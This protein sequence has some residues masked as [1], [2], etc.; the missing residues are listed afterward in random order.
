[1]FVLNIKN[2][3][4]FINLKEVMPGYFQ[5][6]FENGDYFTDALQS[7]VILRA[8]ENTNILIG[9][10]CNVESKIR[11][12]NEE[13]FLKGQFRLRELV[14]DSA[15]LLVSRPD[16]PLISTL[17]TL[18][19]LDVEG[20][21]NFNANFI[22]DDNLLIVDK[23]NKNVRINH[24]LIPDPQYQLYVNSNIFTHFIRV[25][26]TVY[27]S[28]LEVSGNLK[29]LG[30]VNT[31]D[32]NILLTERFS[33]SNDG[34]GP[35][36][37]VNQTGS[38]DIAN[39]M[40]DSQSVLIMKDGGNVGINTIYPT[41]KLTVNGNVLVSSNL[42]IQQNLIVNNVLY[43]SNIE[44]VNTIEI[45]GLNVNIN[46]QLDVTN[47]TTFIHNDVSLGKTV[48]IV[49]TLYTSNIE[50][51]NTI[52]VIGSNVNVKNQLDVTDQVT[53]IHNDVS[54]AK[55]VS[56][57]ETL[58]TSNIESANTIEIA[59]ANVNIKNQLDVTDP[60]TFIH[61]DVS[62][63]KNVSIE[64]TLYTSNIESVNTI[65]VIGS[66]VN[67]KN[68][69]NV[70][71]PVTFI[72]NDV[73]L[74]KNVSIADTLYTSNINSLNT[75]N[76][77]GDVS[78][79]NNI[80]IG[81]TL[82]INDIDGE[83]H[84]IRVTTSGAVNIKDELVVNT[85][86][87]FIHND[88]SLAK[89]VSIV[90]TL[91]TS[92]IESANTIEITGAN[93]NVK[94]LLD[95][96][97]PVTFIHN[98]V[99]LAKNVSIVE[100][101]YTSNIES[102]NT[103]EITGANVN[104]KN[105]LDV[106]D[107]VTFIH[108][109]VSIAKNVSIV[110]TLYTSNI[111]SV[112]TI[113][114]TGAN[115]NVKNVLDVTDPVT[116]IHNDVSIAKNV[117][118]VETLYTSNIESVNTIEITGANVNVKN[119]LDVTDQVTFIH[120]D[121]SIARNISIENTIYT[122]N[123][124]ISGNFKVL[125]TVNTIDTNIILT[126]RFAVSN[127]GTGPAL[128]ITQLGVTDIAV[129]YDD[130][131]VALII[132]DGGN[133]GINTTTPSE[134][135]T[136][137]G[138]T[139]ISSNLM[140]K[141]DVHF[142]ND[143]YIDNVLSTKSFY[144]SNIIVEGDILQVPMGLETKRPLPINAPTGCIFYNSNTI[145]FEGLHD[146]GGGVKEWLPFGGVVD[147]DGDTYITAENTP[148]DNKLTF[149]AGNEVNPIAVFTS[150]SLSV[151]INA[152]FEERLD[153]EKQVT[154]HN[155]LEV[156]NNAVFDQTVL[157]LGTLS[158]GNLI[159]DTLTNVNEATDLIC[160]GILSVNQEAYLTNDTYIHQD[161]H[162]TQ[163]IYTSN[164]TSSNVH[165]NGSILKIPVG[166]D[167][168]R[169]LTTA[170]PTGSIYYNEDTM[171]FE[172][173][174]DLTGTKEW[175]AFGGV[176]DIDGDTYITA[177]NTTNDNTLS[178]FAG[179]GHVPIATLTNTELSVSTNTVIDN[180]LT[181][182]SNM[183]VGDTIH[184][185]NILTSNINILSELVFSGDY[186]VQGNLE[187]I[188]NLTINDT[189]F[190]L[191][192][193]TE[194]V[195]K[196]LA[197]NDTNDYQL[198][199]LFH[200][201]TTCEFKSLFGVY[202]TGVELEEVS[203]VFDFGVPKYWLSGWS[204]KLFD[205]VDF[206]DG[207]GILAPNG[208]NVD[209]TTIELLEDLTTSNMDFKDFI[210]ISMY[211]TNGDRLNE[212]AGIAVNDYVSPNHYFFLG[213][214]DPNHDFFKYKFKLD[215]ESFYSDLPNM[216]VGSNY[217]YRVE[218]DSIRVPNR[219]LHTPGTNMFVVE[220]INT[221]D[222]CPVFSDNS[223]KFNRSTDENTR[224]NKYYVT[225]NDTSIVLKEDNIGLYPHITYRRWRNSSDTVFYEKKYNED[226]GW[227][228]VPNIDDIYIRHHANGNLKLLYKLTYNYIRNGLSET[229][230]LTESEL[231]NLYISNVVNV[232]NH[233]LHIASNIN[234][235]DNYIAGNY[236]AIVFKSSAFSLEFITI[237]QEYI[238]NIDRIGGTEIVNNND[239]ITPIDLYTMLVS[240]DTAIKLARPHADFIDK[241]NNNDIWS[242]YGRL[243]MGLL[244]DQTTI[245]SGVWYDGMLSTY[246]FEA[247]AL[248]LITPTI[249]EYY[250]KSDRIMLSGNE[251]TIYNW[252]DNWTTYELFESLVGADILSLLS[253]TLND[254]ETVMNNSSSNKISV[255]NKL[256]IGLVVSNLSELT[257]TVYDEIAQ[258]IV[259]E[260]LSIV[261]SG[262]ITR[263]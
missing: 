95:V 205:G 233:S 46:N 21:V 214:I 75:I 254:V 249:T 68:Q 53:F 235:N 41:E 105:Q 72:H 152:Y 151:N 232:P 262:Y 136:V 176:M 184:A 59:G 74:A 186:V 130:S 239:S 222:N 88:V 43:A 163:S 110:E 49:D 100:T 69:L 256:R 153:V 263:V 34:T 86:K 108:N 15:F 208:S 71:D 167:I 228:S 170:A 168:N 195:S 182:R 149:Y 97:D 220:F 64:D 164:L 237:T 61:N 225:Q 1:L 221:Y 87:T 39:F 188:G 85:S 150:N 160:V 246:S 213:T 138:N 171:R 35:A 174:H 78:L 8:S 198:M 107:P 234:Y 52:S 250:I 29:I 189:T 57:V 54:L 147:I 231:D 2:T 261:L 224:L 191:F 67:V 79:L 134:K 17:G 36:L 124:E 229:N 131:Q 212:I 42:S 248:H 253:L 26:D 58:Y 140:V 199:T 165:V 193:N 123:L 117:S 126:E 217:G 33:I 179:N 243:V 157:I 50:S 128:E 84:T 14:M 145:R 77:V 129:F 159:T 30:E 135:L 257:G 197:V 181:V 206:T 244:Y 143:A 144:T 92:N 48:S 255:Y 202:E 196:V 203:G 216:T 62:L 242:S 156:R 4:V 247:V 16:Q 180:N 148:N 219:S 139:Y 200:H 245:R 24:T 162:V 60:V 63:A 112:N 27:T 118:I 101:L 177:E 121:V 172:G 6:A 106:T 81:E 94:N 73:S 175:L 22:V 66:N 223:Y 20:D 240:E 204:G 119:L 137:E 76:I 56:I 11:I 23:Y 169:P 166:S 96:T 161:L 194:D 13:I 89:N 218:M 211:K 192:P 5:T 32:T 201:K 215:F 40:D 90:E 122:S 238:D 82:Y 102:V 183:I 99:S 115:V 146:I 113:E 178:F 83:E 111:E 104:V 236:N 133:V 93:V 127:E 190:P 226:I 109:D 91:Y 158:V 7:D 98:D 65:S 37:L 210:N 12:T 114:I 120:N 132:K 80:S 141:L 38:T 103:I 260:G 19:N 251:L 9:V 258:M 185:S 125:G 70:T 116:F 51:V 31:I 55:N 45:T 25:N 154:L 155:T 10:G 44:S 209:M 18:C 28:N 252:N 142:S 259:D 227:G 187:V 173:L 3:F 207:V 230:T 241:V 47:S